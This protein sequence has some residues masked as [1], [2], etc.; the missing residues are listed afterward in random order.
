M[1]DANLPTLRIRC[2]RCRTIMRVAIGSSPTCAQCGYAGNKGP[3]F[4]LGTTTTTTTTTVEEQTW[5]DAPP[6]EPGAWEP[7]QELGSQAGW[8]AGEGQAEQAWSDAPAAPAEG[9]WQTTPAESAWEEA[10]AEPW[11]EEQAQAQAPTKKRG[12]FSR[13]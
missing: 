2:P 9:E 13:K 12:L 11:P 1:A 8:N 10:P 4:P 7:G 3:T 6:Q 5:S